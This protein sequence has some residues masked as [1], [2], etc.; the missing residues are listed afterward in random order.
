MGCADGGGGKGA[1]AGEEE[2]RRRPR[3]IGLR[4]EMRAVKQQENFECLP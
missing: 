4:D 1:G 3:K 2:G